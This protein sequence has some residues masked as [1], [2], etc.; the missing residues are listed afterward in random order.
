METTRQTI[1]VPQPQ[2]NLIQNVTPLSEPLKSTQ[3][4][5]QPRQLTKHDITEYYPFGKI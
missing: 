3:L 1:H 5:I 2:L 4:I